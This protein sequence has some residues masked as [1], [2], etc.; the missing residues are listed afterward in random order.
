[1]AHIHVSSKV[2][3]DSGDAVSELNSLAWGI[4]SFSCLHCCS[5]PFCTP[6]LLEGDTGA[7]IV[8]G[9]VICGLFYGIGVWLWPEKFVQTGKGG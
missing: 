2:Y 5:L 1:M 8:I 3:V 4:S 6:A 9:S 7:A